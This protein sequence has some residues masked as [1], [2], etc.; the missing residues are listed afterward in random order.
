MIS[1]ITGE[2]LQ[3]REDRCFVSVAG[4]V[5]EVLVPAADSPALE[6]QRGQTITLHTLVYLEGDPTRGNLVPRMVGFLRA[7]DRAFFE[8]FTTVKGIGNRTALRALAV[9]VE[10]IASAIEAKDARA[11]VQLD[12]VGKRTAELIVAELAGKVGRF[13]GAPM[14]AAQR[15]QMVYARRTP[16]EEDALSALAALGESRYNAEQLL[17]RA[18]AGRSDLVRAD[19]LI[20]EMLKLRG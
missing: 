5:L 7:D 9:P 14:P 16:A 2:L 20:R 12:G 3:V 10:Q 15:G 11:L 8:L 1:A 13:V 19:Q 17:E 18:K 4:V 6:T